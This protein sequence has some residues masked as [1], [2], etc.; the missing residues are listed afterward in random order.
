[1]QRADHPEGERLI[2]PERIAD[3]ECKL[4]DFEIGGTAD[5]DRLRN[6]CGNCAAG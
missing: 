2:K 3:R 5:S 1:M 4:A 6:F